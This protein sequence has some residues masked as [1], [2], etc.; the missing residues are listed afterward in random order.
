L[1]SVWTAP[2]LAVRTGIRGDAARLVIAVAWLSGMAE[3]LQDAALGRSY[4]PHWGP[5][6]LLLALVMGPLAGLVYFGIAGG[7]LA[8]AGRL[9]GGT[10]D[11]SDARVAL[12]C[13]VVP[14]LVALPLWIPVVGFY[15]LD[16]FTKDQAAPPAGLVAFLALQVVLLLWSWGLRVVTLAEAH[17]FT[18]WRGFSTMM[19]AWLAMAVLIAGVVLGIAALV[20]VPGIM[21]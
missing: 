15:G 20:D 16:V 17:R 14:E 19:L 3:V 12:A 6:A 5:F 2:R 1:R 13:S 7:L 4:P 21:A 18:L 10:A 11:S 9:L 8:G